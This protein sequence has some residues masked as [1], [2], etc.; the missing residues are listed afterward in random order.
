MHVRHSPCTKCVREVFPRPSE[1]DRC[2]TPLPLFY[3][4]EPSERYDYVT[5]FNSK[6]KAQCGGEELCIIDSTCPNR[7]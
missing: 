2:P 5:T 7:V 4:G 1:R 3:Q 6:D